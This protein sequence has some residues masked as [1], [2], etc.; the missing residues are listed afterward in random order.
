MDN[1]DQCNYWLTVAVYTNNRFS[2][3]ILSYGNTVHQQLQAQ[4]EH[5]GFIH[6]TLPA[7]TSLTMGC[8]QTGERSMTCKFR[9]KIT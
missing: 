1:T 4:N 2:G 3:K 9:T 5:N 8:E 7:Y 6:A